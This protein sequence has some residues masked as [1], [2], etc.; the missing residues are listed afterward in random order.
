MNWLLLCNNVTSVAVVLMCWWLTHSN[1]R[2]LFPGRWIAALYSLL[3]LSVLLTGVVRNLA[4]MPF[5]AVP[6]FIVA[7]K[8]IL[9][10]VLL[11]EVYRR[12]RITR[13]M[14]QHPPAPL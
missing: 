9:A 8:G 4:V 12:A 14:R 13:M 2:G 1:S 11:L 10:I 7:T 3:G 5:D 6:W